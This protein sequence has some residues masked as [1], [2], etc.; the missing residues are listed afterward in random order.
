M[1][2]G[3][4]MNRYIKRKDS[5]ILTT[6]EIIDEMGFQNLTTKEICRRQEFVEGSLY[7][8]FKSKD[9]IILGVLDYYIKF[10]EEIGQTIEMKKFSSKESILYYI[11]CFAEYYENYPA[12]TAILN[13]CE[14]LRNEVGVAHKVVEIYNFRTKLMVNFIEEGIKTGQ[15][16]SNIDSENLSDIIL[17]SFS[18][19]ILKWRMRQ[20]NFNLKERLLS[21]LDMILKAY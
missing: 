1:I 13:T 4:N 16:N 20:F 7:K 6:I 5:I 21:T 12:M 19:I 18:A 10:D 17:G 3:D 8:H 11:T 15:F 9:E 14:V 2:G